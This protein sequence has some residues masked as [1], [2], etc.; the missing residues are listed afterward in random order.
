MS[1]KT[2]SLT[3]KENFTLRIEFLSDWHIGS[4]MGRPGDIDRLVQRDRHNLPYIPAKT[5]TGIWRDACER[6]AYG[7][8]NGQPNGVWHQWVNYLFGDQPTDPNRPVDQAEKPPI[9]AALS[10]RSAHFPKELQT[11]LM[12]KPRLHDLVSIIKPGIKI[13][14]DNGC[15]EPDCLR[16]EERVRGGAILTAHCQ[17]NLPDD[18]ESRSVAYALLIAGTQFMERIGGKRRRGSGKCCCTILKE[19]VNGWIDWIEQHLEP[20]AP[21]TPK[22]E[23][24]DTNSTSELDIDASTT[25]VCIDLVIE[26]ISPLIIATRTV[27]NVVE[28]LDYI[29]GSHLLR[30][31]VNKLRRSQL[32]SNEMIGQAIAQKH[33]LV[34]PATVDVQESPGRPVPFCWLA[35]K[36]TGGLRNA[37]KGKVFNQFADD[38]PNDADNAQLKAEHGYF[39]GT[40]DSPNLPAFAAVSKGIATH[41]VIKDDVQRPDTAVGGVFSYEAIAPKTRFRA[42]LRVRHTLAQQIQK[43]YRDQQ[44]KQPKSSDWWLS[45]NGSDRI[46]SS[47]KDDYGDVKLTAQPRSSSGFPAANLPAQSNLYVWLLSDTLIRDQRLRLST[48]LNDLQEELAALLGSELTLYKSYQNKICAMQQT[49]RV[50]SWQSSWGLPRPSLVGF[51]AGSC[52]IFTVNSEVAA[53]RLR[54][55][56]MTG[57]GDRTVEGYGQLCFN[58]PLIM[59][60]TS[61]LKA[62]V[63]SELD[64]SQPADNP[65]LKGKSAAFT[66][67]RII[68]REAW[69]D[70]IRRRYIELAAD[71]QNRQDYLALESTKPPNSQ[72]GALNSTLQQMRSPSDTSIVVN[73]ITKI[74][75][76]SNRHEKWQTNNGNE[77]PALTKIQDLITNQ[78]KIWEILTLNLSDITLTETGEQDLKQELWAEAVRTFINACI[79]AH[80]RDHEPKGQEKELVG[81][82][83]T[84]GTNS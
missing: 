31:I 39:I 69:R 68:E 17:L 59:H 76:I 61:T 27:G 63:S 10:V 22:R 13:N 5:V 54:Q 56:Q 37:G 18:Q 36:L 73:W 48:Q 60:P 75:E 47:K 79:R 50:E 49:N 21:P 80:R 40:S 74:R 35:D 2:T 55:L 53:E 30:L 65:P 84:H 24:N 1:T 57:I 58:D 67:A 77:S 15:A 71:P 42:Q 7:L 8:D 26:A 28:S 33:L 44:S 6:V 4:G 43:A 29:P 38:L 14:E 83:A 45:L 46:G 70:E 11:A 16:L 41:N 34:T 62:T 81:Q 32:L 3:A 52:F 19:P 72:L 25:W 64:E 12:S 23:H 51:K 78:P 82:G 9:P 66:Y 20:A